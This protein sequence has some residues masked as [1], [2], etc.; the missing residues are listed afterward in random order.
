MVD[1]RDLWWQQVDRKI[2]LAP[3]EFQHTLYLL[4]KHIREDAGGETACCGSFLPNFVNSLPNATL[5][6]TDLQSRW[7]LKILK[8]VAAGCRRMLRLA[9]EVQRGPLGIN[10]RQT[11]LTS[12]FKAPLLTALRIKEKDVAKTNLKNKFNRIDTTTHMTPTDFF[13]TTLSNSIFYW[14]F[15]AG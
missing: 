14:E 4:T 15:K 13:H 2:S 1:E 7:V 12:Y 5:A 9:A 8:V 6:L 11:S 3:Y 10:Y